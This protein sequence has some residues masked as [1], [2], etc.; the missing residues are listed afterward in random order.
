MAE[1]HETGTADRAG[2]RSRVV[3]A[4]TIAGGLVVVGIAAA[5]IERA[6]IV[7]HYAD[8]AFAARG[9]PARYRIA[10]IGPFAQ[11]LEDVSIGDP[12]APDL[13]ARVVDVR[14]SYGLHGPKLV[15]VAADGVRL[16]ARVIDGRVTFGAIDRLLPAPS[17]APLA[18]PHVAATLDDA[19]VRLE[20]PAGTVIAAV[21]GRGRLSD[22]FR[23][24]VR[25]A[26]RRLAA[27][28]CVM[29]GA[30][31][32]VRL[33]VDDRR[34]R[35]AGP[36]ALDSL[37]CP[38]IATGAGRAR[39][40]LAFAATLD[41]WRGE[42]APSGFAGQAGRTRFGAL[43]GTIGV[44]GTPRRIEGETHLTV[45]GVA[46]DD[47]AATGARA[48]G[49][50]RY[51]PGAAGLVYAG[52]VTL[53]H[54][55]LDG[56]RRKALAAAG[57]KLA[58]T[59]VAPLASRLASA[60]AAAAADAR[61]TMQVA[62][63]AGGPAGTAVRVRRLD[64]TAASGA[65]ARVTE[66]GGFGWSVAERAWRADGRIEAGGGGLPGVALALTQPRAAA[67]V[68]GTATIAPYVAGGARLA[69]APVRF[70]GGRHTR[71]ATVAT[72][73]GPLGGG[74][75]EGL[76]VPLAGRIG[77][78]D[79]VLGEGCVPIAFRALAIAGT[80]FDTAHLRVCGLDG[81]PIASMRHGVVRAG[82]AVERPRLAGRSGSSPLTLAAD[83]VR[84][85]RAGLEVD[86]L[87][88]RVGAGDAI[89]RLEVARIDGG[90]AGDLSGRFARAGGQIA[91]VPLALSD[92][93]GSWRFANGRLALTGGLA[94]SDPGTSPR[95]RTMAARDVTLTLAGGGIAAS[96]VLAEPRT[97]RE[98]ANVALRHDLRS[99]AGDARLTVPG[100]GFDKAF[101][102][103]ML[104]PLTLGVIAN[105]AGTVAGNGRIAWNAAGV[106]SSGDFATDRIDLAAAFGPVTGIRG[107]I[108]FSDLLGLVTPPAQSATIAEINPGVI[109]AD[110]TVHYRLLPDQRVAVED[111]RWPFAAGT[112]TL[113][114]TVLAFGDGAWRR[115]TFRLSGLDAAAFVQQLALPNLSA[116]GT[117]DGVLPMIFDQAGGRI[118]GGSI[119]A[120]PPGG[121]IAYVGE[122]SRQSI[123]TMGKLAF[124]ALKAIRYSQLSIAL[125]GRLDGEIVSRVAFA[126][127]RQ[128]TPDASYAARLLHDLPFRFNIAVRAPFRALV[129][130]ARS[131]ADPSL[132]LPQAGHGPRVSEAP[133]GAP[134]QPTASE[135]VR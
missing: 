7:A 27:G 107:A 96:G 78:G 57:N 83:R 106:T 108:H 55:R 17:G 89:T 120:R 131:Y 98:V 93:A 58:G 59:P 10:A 20:A 67:P 112:L 135:A 42:L 14:L 124:D 118:E 18:L 62:L 2:D 115:M 46:T 53:D 100:I 28:G 23:G 114:P 129:G 41:R 99:G 109:V 110:G 34:L 68:A 52:L 51:V 5:W 85:D 8:R 92:A 26:S 6:P 9:V 31:A 16:R 91:R 116:T 113:E 134:I 36:L 43:G 73:D 117:F 127:V 76:S 90:F 111:A 30:T 33:A 82:F 65:H 40:D 49:R 84:V 126:G 60:L 66:G 35:V 3:V 25:A 81:G 97:G 119:V 74:A 1:G 13:V 94:L 39:A 121:T 105:V 45:A 64:L 69:L 63:T 61:A 123:G 54:A 130:T 104:T 29:S 15:A 86:A 71:F 21:S 132:L 48:D 37:T 4:G 77:G 50:Y 95:F 75:I 72:L 44:G 87:A 11:R 32:D 70:V 88:A 22:G 56:R 19:I 47:V 103:D 133:G 128:A 101:Q 24:R 38:T 80:K 122:L 125:D 12:R 102:P 79:L